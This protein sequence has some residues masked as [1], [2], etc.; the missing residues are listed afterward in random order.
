MLFPQLLILAV[1]VLLAVYLPLARFFLGVWV[2]WYAFVG[3]IMVR[4]VRRRRRGVTQ[5]PTLWLTSD[6]LGFTS[7]C[8]APVSCPRAIVASALRIFATVNR[9][10]RDLLVFRDDGDNVVLSTPLG[11]WRP[12]DVDSVTETLGIQPAG[13]RFVNSATELETAAHGA[14]LPATFAVRAAE[15]RCVTA[16][17][18][19]TGRVDWSVT[20][21]SDHPELFDVIADASVV[22]AATGAKAA[23]GPGLIVPVVDELVAYDP[24]TGHA[25]WGVV[26]PGDSQVLPGLLTGSVV[27]VSQADGSL[28]GLSEADGHQLWH[29]PAPEGCSANGTMDGTEPN[30]VILG[31]AAQGGTVSAVVG[32]ACPAGATSLRSILQMERRDGRGASQMVGSSTPRWPRPSTRDLRL[33]SWWRLRS[34]S[35]LRRTPRLTSLHPRG[36]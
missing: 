9:Q 4:A 33:S 3:V 8:G 12:E 35:S 11:V 21:P 14:P 10:T 24:T 28:V 2:L 22:L 30:A 19:A 18:V 31:T 25:K 6:S 34:A 32:Y 20:P 27:V 17:D 5:T 1:L 15:G 13:R 29:D 16:I 23:D 7:R 36:R 26:I